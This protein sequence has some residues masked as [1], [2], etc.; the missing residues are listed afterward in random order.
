MTKPMPRRVVAWITG[1]AALL[2]MWGAVAAM[3]SSWEDKFI[4]SYETWHGE[5]DAEWEARLVHGVSLACG[6]LDEGNDLPDTYNALVDY[7]FSSDQST[8]VISGAVVYQCTEYAPL[9]Q[10]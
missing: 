7:G 4:A 9:L 1:L 10:R 3:S 2:L 6:L 5:V 8:S